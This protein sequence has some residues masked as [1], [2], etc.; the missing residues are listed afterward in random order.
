VRERERER[1][2]ESEI[3][4][5]RKRKK[6]KQRDIENIAHHDLAKFYFYKKGNLNN[7]KHHLFQEL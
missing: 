5:A 6:E 7:P 3:E 4:I 1:E 2:R